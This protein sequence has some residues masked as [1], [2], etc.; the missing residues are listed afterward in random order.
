VEKPKAKTE[1]AAVPAEA[2]EV[3]KEKKEKTKKEEIAGIS[4]AE[5]S[6]LDQLKKDIIERKAQLKAE[7]MSGGQQNKDSQIVEWVA[8]MNVLKEKEC[9]GST[10]KEDKKEGK[11]KS[12]A[13]LSSEEQLE[14][15]KLRG[16]IETYKHRLKTEFGYSNKDMKADQDLIDMEKRIAELEKRS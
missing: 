8:R 16:E 11:K 4:P 7:G 12:T 2:V 1:P 14:L 15:D 6:E 9:P 10:Q 13:P 5:R 3:K